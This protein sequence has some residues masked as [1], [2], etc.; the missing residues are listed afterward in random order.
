MIHFFP[1]VGETTSNKNIPFT[2]AGGKTYTGPRSLTN[3]Y[4][5][6]EPLVMTVGNHLNFCLD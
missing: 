2:E 3:Q 4:D 6:R 5:H 1:F